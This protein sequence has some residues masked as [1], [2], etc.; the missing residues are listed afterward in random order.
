MVGYELKEEEGTI[1]LKLGLCK[2]HGPITGA[3]WFE[4]DIET[5]NSLGEDL[6]NLSIETHLKEQP[7][8]SSIQGEKDE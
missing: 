3:I 8:K 4:L 7:Q 5:A 2:G 6:L 1:Y